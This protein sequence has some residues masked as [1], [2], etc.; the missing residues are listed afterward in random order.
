MTSAGESPSSRGPGRPVDPDIEKRLFAAV[1]EIYAETGWAGFTL[2]AAAT[3][4]KVGKA[5]IYRRWDSKEQ[6]IVEAVMSIQSGVVPDTGTLRGDLIATV[7]GEL[8]YYLTPHGLV[9]LRAQLEAKAYPEVFG[10]AM[11]RF[12]RNRNE[13]GRAILMA[14]E[15]RGELTSDTDSW[16][17]LDAIGGMTINHFLAT[18]HG[19]LSDLRRNRR[20]FA[21]AVVDFALRSIRHEDNAAS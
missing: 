6:L 9:L 21:E 16:V 13:S 18:P 19:R 2:H 4:A 3:K 7:E 15:E 14:A 11:E 20:V 8:L 10:A 17:I 1:L 12:R 5:A